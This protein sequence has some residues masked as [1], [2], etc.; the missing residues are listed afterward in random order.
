MS[1][2]QHRVAV[3]PLETVGLQQGVRAQKITK[4]ALEDINRLVLLQ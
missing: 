4:R 3:K 2:T 1:E